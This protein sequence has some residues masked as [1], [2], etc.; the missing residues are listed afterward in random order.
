MLLF[1]L[2]FSLPLLSS[3]LKLPTFNARVK[4]EKKALTYLAKMYSFGKSWYLVERV[5]A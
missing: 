1:Q 4:L 3:L 5:V 2:T